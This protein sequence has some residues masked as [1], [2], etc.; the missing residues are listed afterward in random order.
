MTLRNAFARLVHAVHRSSSRR[1][2][3][4]AWAQLVVTA[5]ASPEREARV[6]PTKFNSP[7]QAL[8]Q[9]MCGQ[10]GWSSRYFRDASSGRWCVEV[11]WGVGDD[12]RHTFVSDDTSD[13]SI[14]GAKKGHAA[15][16][17]VALEGLDAI[18]RSVN[19]KP[20][21]TV[22]DAL[23]PRFSST[24][25]VLDGSAPGSWVRLWRCL[26]RCSPRARAVGI[27]VE[28]NLQTPPVLVQVCAQ[29][30]DEETS[31][32]ILELPR[33]NPGG[34][35]SADL[36]RLLRDATVAKVFCDGTAGSD[37]R[38]LSVD[39]DLAL[40]G[41]QFACHDLENLA[42]DL[43]GAT[44]VP[45]GLARIFNLAWPD[46]AFR[47]TKD[48]KDKSSVRY[49]VDVQN[50]RRAPPEALADVPG[51]IRRYAA[52]DAWLTLLS[53]DGLRRT[54]AGGGISTVEQSARGAHGGAL[55]R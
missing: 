19:L 32:C 8:E 41:A 21:R 11:R 23:G 7:K 54:R 33:S 5:P 40:R 37:K 16:A 31:L 38:S 48:N 2:E 51:P 22:E 14:P 20:L 42:S 36:R 44:S 28:G 13:E 12:K 27:D 29:I 52:M 46:S 3:N 53:F 35:L 50:G 9:G 25:L 39:V 1:S 55:L 17:A 30:P 47:A 34:N 26:S 10:H 49:F 15:A 43:A 4:R 6:M 45:R 24:C 18:V